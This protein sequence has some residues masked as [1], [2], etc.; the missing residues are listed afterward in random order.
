MNARRNV[1]ASLHECVRLN[2]T[3]RFGNPI[4]LE[5]KSVDFSR[6]GIGL[7]L[8]QDLLAP[9][10]VVSLNLPRKLHSRAVVQ[11][12]RR[13]AQDGKVRVGLQL[14]NPEASVRF[15]FAAC[16]LLAF[17]LLSQVSLSRGRLFQRPATTSRCTM[18]LA[19]MK[20]LIQNTVGK[21]GYLTDDEKTFLTI[22]HQRMA[23]ADYSKWLDSFFNEE[24]K[25]GAARAWYRDTFQAQDN[26]VMNAYA[27]QT[28]QVAGGAQ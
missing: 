3:D 6:K 2:G 5:G 28:E 1:R 17:A 23:P 7:V 11:W 27:P 18:S 19:D 13:D 15:R 4:E 16:F 25:R 10:A 26:A 12:S 8:D 24:R 14:I 22:Q 20:S 9:G 21:Y